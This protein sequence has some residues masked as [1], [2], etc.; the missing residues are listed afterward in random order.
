VGHVTIA[1]YKPRPGQDAGLLEVVKTHVA[2]LRAEGL[3]TE[4]KSIAMKCK[5]GTIV[6]VFEWASTAAIEAAHKNENVMAM[7]KRF[8]EVCEIVKLVDLAESKDMFAGFE[9]IDF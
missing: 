3:A 6:E 2:I 5:D 7:W 1:A 9:P 8:D 4:R